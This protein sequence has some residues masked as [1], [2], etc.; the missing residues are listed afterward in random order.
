M[1]KQK[2]QKRLN[3]NK[4]TIVNL[5]KEEMAG[6]QGGFFITRLISW[7]LDCDTE[8]IKRPSVACNR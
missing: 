2:I 8:L 4:Q 6:V 5:G 7:L 3:L 1:K